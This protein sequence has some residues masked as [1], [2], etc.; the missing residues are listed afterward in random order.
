MS[1]IGK[2]KIMLRIII[3]IALAGV[4][5]CTKTHTGPYAFRCV[6]QADCARGTICMTGACQVPTYDTFDYTVE[7]NASAK[8]FLDN[9]KT[10]Q[11]NVVTAESLTAGMIISS[12]VNVPKYGSYV[13]GG[14]AT[15]DSDAKRR[16]LGVR[17]DNVYT[18]ECSLQMAIGAVT[19]S[20]AL[21]GLA[22]TGKAGP[23]DK[24]DLTSLG[25]VDV[26]ATIRT[27]VAASGSDIPEDPD[28]PQTF[29]SVSK[30]INVCTDDGHQTTR[31]L[32]D[33]YKAEAVADPNGF[34]SDA[35]LNLGRKLIRQDTVIYA[36]R[37]GF[38]HLNAY[39]CTLEAGLF[40]P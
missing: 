5:S 22:V 35:V 10:H 7:I 12:I 18:K 25:V 16:F 31:D 30:R 6:E 32:C 23:V 26:A 29:T 38:Q 15:Y 37:L 13:Y 1:F 34:V 21:V 19:H 24:N 27:D 2:S 28:F 36:L 39:Q 9:L 20:R 11:F 8:A 4:V 3:L 17:V 14:F 40:S 33:K